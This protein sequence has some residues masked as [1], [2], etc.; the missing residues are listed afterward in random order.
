MQHLPEYNNGVRRPSGKIG[1]ACTFSVTI[2]WSLVRTEKKTGQIRAFGEANLRDTEA[3][4]EKL[5][6]NEWI[7]INKK[8]GKESSHVFHYHCFA[9]MY[10]R[11]LHHEILNG[12][13][14]CSKK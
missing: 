14:F 10:E 6:M 9:Y 12:F 4:N 3:Q 7:A 13:S 1:L 2:P 11:R 8:N 5:R